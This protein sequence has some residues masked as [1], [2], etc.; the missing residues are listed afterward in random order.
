MYKKLLKKRKLNFIN[1]LTKVESI[2]NVF[3]SQFVIFVNLRDCKMKKN[4]LSMACKLS[5]KADCVSVCKLILC[6]E[7]VD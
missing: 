7:T 6:L 1:E 5:N 2:N 4:L 3:L